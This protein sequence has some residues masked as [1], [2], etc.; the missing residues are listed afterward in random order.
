MRTIMLTYP[1]FQALPQGIKKM[2]LASETF[3]FSEAQ[4]HAQRP[5]LRPAPA[6]SWQAP[7]TPVLW[8][9]WQP[10]FGQPWRN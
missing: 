7:Y 2:L 6:P 1:G 8:N 10:A 9:R 4:P 3:F 5:E